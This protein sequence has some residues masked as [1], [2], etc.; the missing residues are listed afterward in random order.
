MNKQ[1]KII[2]SFLIVGAFSVPAIS[3][4]IS[5]RV[6][7]GTIQNRI[8]AL[9][10][11]E[12]LDESQSAE[13]AQL[14]TQYRTNCSK[15]ASGRSS[16]SATRAT[17]AA[18]IAAA[19][20]AAEPVVES[21]VVTPKS[22]LNEYLDYLQDLCTELKS[23]IDTLSVNGVS[24]TDL[25]PLQNQYDAD[26]TNIDKSAVVEIDAETAAANKA[27]GLCPDGSKPNKFGCCEGATFKDMGNLTFACCPD[28]GGEC[29]QPIN[30]GGII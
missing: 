2:I 9:K 16:F 4:D 21:V 27:A 29:Y 8:D 24:K 10:G 14:Q 5:D 1:I 3:A 7:C 20:Q 22:V 23:N 17:S 26:C 15:P 19:S 6:D 28:E 25:Q 13:L 11:I 30:T 12:T 18:A